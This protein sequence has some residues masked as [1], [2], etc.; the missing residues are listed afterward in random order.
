M[1]HPLQLDFLHARSPRRG[2]LLLALSLLVT[3]LVVIDYVRLRTEQTQLQQQHD[4]AL[5][6]VRR[7]RPQLQQPLGDARLV[8]RELS[9]ARAVLT[10]LARP[11]DA[12]FNELEHVA[13]ED[14]TLL[15]I[16]P[17]RATNLIRLQGE[18]RDYE[19]LLAY[20]SALEDSAG[21][22]NALLTAHEEQ[23]TGAVRF[24]LVAQWVGEA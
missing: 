24:S 8:S 9:S 11:W 14:V 13:T 1:M 3:T 5:N 2:W 21:F 4:G 19:A 7:E 18:A 15:A 23:D 20:I 16:Q 6:L 22:A 17:D 10:D 12:L